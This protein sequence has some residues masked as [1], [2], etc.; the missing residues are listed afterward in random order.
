MTK[1]SKEPAQVQAAIYR[2]ADKLIAYE[3]DELDLKD[4]LHLFGQ[5]IKTGLAWELQGHYGRTAR[6]YID[7]GYITEKGTVMM[8]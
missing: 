2:V 6:A 7:A 4:T 3:N 5:L 8:K 1:L